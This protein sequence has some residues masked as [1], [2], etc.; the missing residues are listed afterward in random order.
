MTEEKMIPVSV[1]DAHIVELLKQRD[2]NELGSS[3][4]F[5]HTEMLNA[6]VEELIEIKKEAISTEGNKITEQRVLTRIKEIECYPL[7]TWKCYDNHYQ[8]LIDELRKLLELK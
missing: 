6:M 3:V 2:K 8:M 7:D 4:Y 5:Y 1:V